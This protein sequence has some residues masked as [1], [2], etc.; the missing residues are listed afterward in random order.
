MKKNSR[1]EEKKKK[2]KDAKAYT[3]K[4]QANAV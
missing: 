2:Q 1:L 3:Q 4:E